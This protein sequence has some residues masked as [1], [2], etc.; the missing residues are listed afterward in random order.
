ML[1]FRNLNDSFTTDLRRY[2]AARILA[3]ERPKSGEVYQ[4]KATGRGGYLGRLTAW[5]RNHLIDHLEVTYEGEAQ[6]LRAVLAAGRMAAGA[7][8]DDP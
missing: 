2:A 8:L 6:P 7:S 4:D 5:L 1:R 3:T